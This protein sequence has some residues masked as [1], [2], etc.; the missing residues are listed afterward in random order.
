MTVRES[1]IATAI[2]ISYLFPT[3]SV[4]QSTSMDDVKAAIRAA[5]ERKHDYVI[6]G[7]IEIP[8][9]N[10]KKFVIRRNKDAFMEVDVS[11]VVSN[12]ISALTE[13]EIGRT[14]PA[15]GH[16]GPQEAR[17]VGEWFRVKL[18]RGCRCTL[19]CKSVKVEFVSDPV[20]QKPFFIDTEN[21]KVVYLEKKKA[22][23]GK[24]V[25]IDCS[26]PNE[27]CNQRVYAWD[28]KCCCRSKSKECYGFVSC[29]DGWRKDYCCPD[30]ADFCK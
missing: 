26:N 8:S 21:L 14:L 1:A 29:D 2:V 10:D 23:D 22:A 12:S 20:V 27:N 30:K 18:K 16:A 19:H 11:A 25:Q 15:T 24:T 17:N 5:S 4:A 9:G 13:Q 28:C 3:L 7:I 6:E